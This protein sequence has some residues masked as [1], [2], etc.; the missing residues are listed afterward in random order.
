MPYISLQTKWLETVKLNYLVV[1]KVRILKWVS[2][3]QGRSVRK[4]VFFVEPQGDNW[5]P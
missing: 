2:L 4:A 3:A 1:L 5:F